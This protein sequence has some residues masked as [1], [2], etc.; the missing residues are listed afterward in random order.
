[1][2]QKLLN[3]RTL[4]FDLI[5]CGSAQQQM[6]DIVL[7]KKEP[8][9]GQADEIMLIRAIPARYVRQALE[10]TA[11]ESVTEYAVWGGVPPWEPNNTKGG[12]SSLKTLCDGSR[13]RDKQRG[14]ARWFFHLPGL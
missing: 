2:I 14:Q 7:N 3:E 6:H 13:A 10:C 5:I 9:Y 12:C 11:E 8:L 1:M 4:R